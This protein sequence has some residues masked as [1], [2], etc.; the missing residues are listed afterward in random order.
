MNAN[1][2]VTLPATLRVFRIVMP[3][4]TV[5]SN[6]ADVPP[7][8]MTVFAPGLVFAAMPPDQKTPV[9]IIVPLDPTV[10]ITNVASRYQGIFV[11]ETG[12]V[13]VALA[14]SVLPPLV[15]CGV[16]IIVPDAPVLQIPPAVIL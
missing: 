4:R 8:G 15:V 9:P 11:I 13:T 2:G 10:R 12:T 6:V 3:L 5:V 16:M 7:N 1:I 14:P